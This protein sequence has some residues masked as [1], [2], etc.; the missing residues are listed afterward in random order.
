MSKVFLTAL[1]L[2][3]ISF[4]VARADDDVMSKPLDLKFTAV[5]GKQVDLAQ[6]RGKVVL[7]DFWA[8][9]CPSCVEE[10]PDVVATYKKYHDQGLEVLGVSLD[11]DK[12]AM[13]GFAKQNGMV[14]P[15]YFDGQGWDNAISSGFG[16]QEIPAMLLVGKDGKVVKPDGS[17]NLAHQVEKQLLKPAT[18]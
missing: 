5:D 1:L 3:F 8:T 7:I 17:G 10:V 18:Q 12:N 13:L 11:Q 6:Y 15:Q 4:S 16:V 14:W 9:W 2:G